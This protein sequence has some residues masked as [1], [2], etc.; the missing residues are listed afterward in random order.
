MR[1]ISDNDYSGDPDG[2]FQL[3]HLLL[4]PSV[5]IRAVIGSHLR[6]GDPLDSSPCTAANAKTEADTIIGLV[7]LTGRVPSLQGSN[8][9]LADPSTPARSA[10]AEAIVQEALRESPLPLYA[11]FGGG[12]TELASALLLEPAVADRMTAVWIGGPEYPAH[13]DAPP[14]IDEESE[15]NLLIDIAA[16]QVVFESRVP[17]WQ[18]PR[19]AYRQTIMSMAEIR[20]EI[21]PCGR[22]G[23][24]LVS[25]LDRVKA[26][27]ADLGWD[28]G[29][30]FILGDNPLVLLTALQSSFHADPS[31]SRYVTLPAPRIDDQ[32]RYVHDS[33]GRP[34]RVYTDLDIRLLFGDM[35]AKLRAF[36]GSM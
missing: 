16:A 29:E 4:S 3:A 6:E 8:A 19:D 10:G 28:L 14:G 1:V 30:T 23:S 26:R 22:L 9:P 2:L 34:I 32:G 13:A 31:S 33:G 18:V 7:G 25:K 5:D 35:L 20:T 17:L 11:V 12:L 24:H 27:V 36:A 21:G 15:Y